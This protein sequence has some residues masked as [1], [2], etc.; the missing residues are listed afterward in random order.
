MGNISSALLTGEALVPVVFKAV[1]Q[2]VGSGLL[3]V[4]NILAFIKHILL[5]LTT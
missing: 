5:V 1:Y 4:Y 3:L 2:T